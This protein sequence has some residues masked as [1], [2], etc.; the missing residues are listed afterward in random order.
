MR[1]IS[2]VL[3]VPP[4]EKEVEATTA[5]A[6]NQTLTTFSDLIIS[7]AKQFGII[8]TDQNDNQENNIENKNP[9][10]LVHSLLTGT[11]YQPSNVDKEIGKGLKWISHDPEMSYRSFIR[12]FK[13]LSYD[14]NT[15]WIIVTPNEQEMKIVNVGGYM[16]TWNLACVMEDLLAKHG[17]ISG[18]KISSPEL[19]SLIFFFL[20]RLVHTMSRTLVVDVT[21]NLLGDWY[22]CLNFAK[23]NGFKVG[24]VMSRLKRVVRAAFGVGANSSKKEEKTELEKL[25]G[26]L[27]AK[28]KKY[29]K[30]LEEHERAWDIKGNNLMDKCFNELV[31]L[32][33]KKV[34]DDLF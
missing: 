22:S 26:N 12:K 18:N 8:T 6:A 25:I 15:E 7:V 13:K 29:K 30:Q 32:K 9:L 17:D 3:E 34:A 28:L 2:T 24:F 19:K 20:C 1:S 10:V 14:K 4:P 31:Q 16:I 5:A 33:W 11:K 23:S 21:E 27:E